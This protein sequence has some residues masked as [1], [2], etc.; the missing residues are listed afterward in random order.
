MPIYAY[1]CAFCASSR[2]VFKPIAELDRTEVCQQCGAGMERRISAVAVLGDYAGYT[3]PITDKWIEGRRA[4]EENLARH[5]CRVYEPGE[6]EGFVRRKAV[7]QE[8]F[9]ETMGESAA[10]AVEAL[11]SDKRERLCAEIQ[12]G[13]DVG[14]TRQTA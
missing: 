1:K 6:R 4:H 5:G 13:L 11:P 8:Q 10:A 9:L 7:E 2:D 12:N 3:C 14:V